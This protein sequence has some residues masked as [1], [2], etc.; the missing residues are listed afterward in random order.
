MTSS[1]ENFKSLDEEK[2]KELRKLGLEIDEDILTQIKDVYFLTMGQDLLEIQ[3][4]FSAQ[5]MP[6]VAKIS[7]RIKSSSGNIGLTK[8]QKIAIDLEAKAQTPDIGKGEIQ[9]LIT[10]LLNEYKVTETLIKNL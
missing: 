3:K 4:Y 9:Q 5:D 7:H 6:G 2:I 1:Y 10:L 8:Q